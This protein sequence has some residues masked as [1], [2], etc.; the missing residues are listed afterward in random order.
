MT[1][2]P[3]ISAYRFSMTQRSDGMDCAR[4]GN[5]NEKSRNGASC[6]LARELVSAGA[7]DA[8]VR[9]LV[10]G[11]ISLEF[12]SLHALATRTYTESAGRP[13]MTKWAPHPGIG[14]E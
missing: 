9:L 10:N 4:F 6:K 7:P 1:T 5:F 11:R 3:K 8:P 13:R 14:G 12:A 2:F